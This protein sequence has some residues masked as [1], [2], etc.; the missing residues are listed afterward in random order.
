MPPM[1]VPVDPWADRPYT[2]L[3][4]NHTCRDSMGNSNGTNQGMIGMSGGISRNQIMFVFQKKEVGT[5]DVAL[6]EKT[7]TCDE[8]GR[9]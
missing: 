8:T 1:P 5:M 2:K 3:R 7:E 4:K 9:K 6:S